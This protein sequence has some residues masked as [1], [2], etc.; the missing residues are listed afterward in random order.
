MTTPNKKAWGKPGVL[1]S[2]A[3]PPKAITV[4]P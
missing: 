4:D 2:L 3:Y 1:Y